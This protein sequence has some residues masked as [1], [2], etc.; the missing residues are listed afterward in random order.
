MNLHPTCGQYGCSEPATHYVRLLIPAKGHPIDNALK[1]IVGLVLCEPHAKAARP[2]QF[3]HRDARDFLRELL[4]VQ[5]L[6]A[7]DFTRAQVEAHPVSDPEY[8]EFLQM[9]AQSEGGG[10][11]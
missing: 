7:P 10:T 1:M 2:H 8:Q 5:G 6:V 4:A 9:R 3:L 11:A